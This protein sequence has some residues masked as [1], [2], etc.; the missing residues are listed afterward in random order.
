MHFDV[1][2]DTL[3]IPSLRLSL[4]SNRT[5][6]LKGG[7]FIKFPYTINID[8]I[9]RSVLQSVRKLLGRFAFRSL[10]FA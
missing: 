4:K 9:A 1:L 5:K 7:K 3:K 6:G 2:L 10:I 8:F